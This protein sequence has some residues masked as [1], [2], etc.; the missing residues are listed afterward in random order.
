MKIPESQKKWS[1]YEFGGPIGTT[2]WTVLLPAVVY[3]MFFCVRF[4][5]GALL[6]RET[7]NLAPFTSFWD[8]ITPTWEAAL[9]YAV[10]I[11]FQGL[12]QAFI[13]GKKVMGRPVTDGSRLQYKMNGVV[14]FIITFVVL[15]IA[16]WMGWIKFDLIYNNFGA[17]ISVVLIFSYLF[18][19]FLYFYG[20]KTKQVDRV[21]GNF[22]H[23]FWMGVSLNPRIPPI[24]GFD[25]KFF[26]EARPGL[27]GWV[28]INFSLMGVQYMRHGFVTLP[29]ILVCAFH[30]IYIA[31]YFWNELAILTTTDIMHDKFGFMLVF[32]DLVWVPFTYVIQAMYLLEHT[33]TL[34]IWGAALIII[35]NFLGYC[36]FRMV[37]IQKHNFRT[38]PDKPIWGKKAEYI[39][40]KQGN[41]LLV[42][43][44]WGWSRH[45]NFLGDILMALAWCLPCLFDSIVPYF[46][47]IYFVLLLIHRERRDNKRCAIKYGENW[48]RYTERVPWRIIPKIY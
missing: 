39:K 30:F 33:H 1:N 40:T 47:V 19:L 38:N 35:L 14:S 9:I 5:G 12:M 31:D 6:P 27:I 10:W 17:L 21:T 41:L 48:D 8:S 36:I 26:C 4:N 22:I 34:P 46:Y 7:I 43:G 24:T 42:S 20:Y 32:G 28:V 44:F 11:V 13:P 15:G 29:M 37:N 23:D 18:S 45:F 16:V 25:L 3:Y 2:F